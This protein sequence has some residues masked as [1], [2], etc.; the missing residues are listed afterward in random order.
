KTSA[1]FFSPEK[2]PFPPKGG[3]KTPFPLGRVGDGLLGRVGDGLL[4]L[5]LF[6]LQLTFAGNG[7]KS[8]PEVGIDEK[9]G[10]QIALQSVFLDENGKQISM[11]QII[12]KPTVL[13]FVYYDCPGLCNPLMAEVASQIDRIDLTPAKDYQLVCVSIDETETSAIAAKKKQNILTGMQKQFPPDGWRFL[14]GNKENILKLTSSAGFF[15]KKEGG[16]IAHSPTLILVS[17]SGKIT[18]YLMGTTFLPFDLKMAIIEASEGK[19]SP[20]IAKILKFCFNYDPE[21]R[22]YVL[23][24]TRIAGAGILL[25]VIV[26]VIVLS[27]KPKKSVKS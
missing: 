21:G 22:K 10:Q 4:F 23:N 8:K 17:P 18:R 14:T 3:I 24:I 20:T 26:L 5:I 1:P 11:K 19:V 12:N 6:S 15:F 7:E 13:M 25:I 27:V 9:L 16:Q 2:P